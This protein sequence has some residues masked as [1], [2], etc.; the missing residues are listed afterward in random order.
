[1]KISQKAFY[2]Q[3]C[4][5]CERVGNCNSRGGAVC[6]ICGQNYCY[7]VRHDEKVCDR[8]IRISE[9]MG[10]NIGTYQPSYAERLSDGFNM[11]S[12]SEDG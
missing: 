10:K 6:P 5:Q 9:G 3:Q 8:S 7:I 12:Q 1:M 11:L 4:D 2:K